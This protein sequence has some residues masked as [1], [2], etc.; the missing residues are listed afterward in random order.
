MKVVKF[1]EVF[2]ELRVN[3]INNPNINEELYIQSPITIT[4]TKNWFQRN[5]DKS[6]RID[7]VFIDGL[8]VVAMTG[9]TDINTNYGLCE[10]YIMVNPNLQSK[11]YG[12]KSTVYTVNHAF[13]NYNINKVFLYSNA[14]NEKANKLYE[15]VGF[16][17]EGTLKEHRFKNGKFV[18]R[19][20]FGL[21]KSDWENLNLIQ[22]KF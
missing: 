3:W 10:F 16:K 19:N 1:D 5:V 9:L 2:I 15:K 18:D 22:Q 17:L 20:I 14:N 12:F 13:L 21:T 11:G 6:N 4:E 8:D 7:L